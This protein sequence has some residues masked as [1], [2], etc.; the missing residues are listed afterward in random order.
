MGT[1]IER[2]TT[3]FGGT[4]QGTMEIVE[5]EPEKSMLFDQIDDATTKLVIGGDFPGM[6]AS[7]DEEIRPR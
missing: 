1:V 3:R 4:T 2:K 5:F 6:D 7:M